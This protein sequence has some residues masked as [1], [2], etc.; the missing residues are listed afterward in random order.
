[1]RFP[2][3][4]E[5]RSWLAAIRVSLIFFA[6]V[7]GA[8]AH[9][10]RSQDP[11]APAD[12]HFA[13]GL[14]LVR[15]GDL[16]AAESEL[17]QAAKSN[18]SDP[19]V[20][21]TLAT[22][23]AMEKKFDASSDFF[24]AALKINPADLRS[25]QYLAANLWQLH[26]Y[27]EAKQHLQIILKARTSDPQATLLLG[28]VSE[29][30]GDYPAAARLLAS[31]P[32][33][34]RRQPEA[35]VALAKSYYHI[36]EREKAAVELGEMSRDP[37]ARD[38]LPLAAHAA[39]EM[40]DY[41]TAELLL[42][43]ASPS[44]STQY[45]LAL[46]KFHA[47]NFRESENI[48]LRLRDSGEHNADVTRLLAWCY[49]RQGR[50]DDAIRIFREAIQQNPADEAN[51]LDL[52]KL[53]LAIR[54]YSAALELAKRTV[55]AFP[56][57]A[58]ALRLQGSVELATEQY[59]D[60]AKTYERATSLDISNVDSVLGL[61][62]AQH[63]AGMET[64]AQQTL[65]SA[66]R[67]FPAQAP[68]ELELALVLLKQ[69][70]AASAAPLERAVQLLQS[71]VKHDPQLAE[72]Q[73]QL[74]ELELNRGQMKLAVLHLENAVK[75]SPESA[76]AHFSLARA[77]RRGGREQDAAAQMAIFDR[78]KDKNSPAAAKPTDAPTSN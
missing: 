67:R 29:N 64:R 35:R 53:L 50:N 2:F 72:A 34:V 68:F 61:A 4:T 40:R 63:G 39:D 76:R 38:S 56:A 75:I 71:A 74:G 37:A 19:E 32:D 52:G 36:G 27:A 18:S 42:A 28:M 21:S 62:R 58:A 25:R 3:P 13:R 24:R 46:V 14:D 54:S 31:V 6:C 43:G 5:G 10:A 44:A 48:L 11:S 26:R 17:R 57:S 30:T 16:S 7:A 55:G 69:N 60:A 1:V 45:Q 41:P 77:Y 51:F 49:H 70:E 65:E 22:V 9:P 73:V 78:L 15:A 20:L 12:A 33:L 8:A 47:G 59:F 66:L 23:L